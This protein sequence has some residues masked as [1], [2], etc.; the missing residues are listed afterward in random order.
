MNATAGRQARKKDSGWIAGG[1]IGILLQNALPVVN[2]LSLRCLD[3]GFRP[4]DEFRD[5]VDV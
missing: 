1:W 2:P 5:F 4:R 3:A